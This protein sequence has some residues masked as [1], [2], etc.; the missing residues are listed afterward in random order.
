MKK[1]K[2]AKAGSRIVQRAREALAYAKGKAN[3]SGFRLHVPSDVDVKAL[4][5]QR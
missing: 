1:K 2:A 3:P 4:R 5:L